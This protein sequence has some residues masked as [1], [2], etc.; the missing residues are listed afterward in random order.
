LT[1][2]HLDI[3]YPEVPIKVCVAYEID[4][5]EVGYRPDQEYLS[6]VKPVYVEL[7]SFDGSKLATAKLIADL[8]KAAL[9]YVA[10]LSESLQAKPLLISVGPKREQTIKYY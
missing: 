5:Q 6:R 9:Q 3:A 8:P 1:L 7:P 4:G 2:T 10:F